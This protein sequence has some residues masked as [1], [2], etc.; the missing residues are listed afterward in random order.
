MEEQHGENFTQLRSCGHFYCNNCLL[1]YLLS[2][3]KEGNVL[4]MVCPD[5]RCKVNI[6][7]QDLLSIMGTEEY[8]KWKL[9]E[10]KKKVEVDPTLFFCPRCGETVQ[11]EE[12]QY[13]Q[14]QSCRFTFCTLCRESWHPANPCPTTEEYLKK[15]TSNRKNKSKHDKQKTESEDLAY[16]QRNCMICPKCRSAIEKDGGCNKMICSYCHSIFCWLCGKDISQIGYTH[17]GTTAQSCVLISDPQ[18]PSQDLQLQRNYDV[19]LRAPMLGGGEKRNI[20]AGIYYQ[21][22]SSE[23]GYVYINPKNNFDRVRSRMCPNCKQLNMKTERNNH[24]ICYSC[25]THICFLCGKIIRS[26][27]H[28]GAGGCK[29]H[30]DIPTLP[31]QNTFTYQL[32]SA[33]PTYVPPVASEPTVTAN[34]SDDTTHP[35]PASSN[36]G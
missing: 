27:T 19:P 8:D 34:T 23:R 3:V 12:D 4:S 36:V 18:L 14:C 24:M 16:L 13:G 7:N 29:Q 5:T 17:F 9:L 26:T 35:P 1:N 15:L 20:S 2:R 30:S 31:P 22:D 33:T 32:S 6:D 11:A 21:P 25:K 28:F 10:Q